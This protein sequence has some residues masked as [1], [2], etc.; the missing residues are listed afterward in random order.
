MQEMAILCRMAYRCMEIS[1]LLDTV[2]SILFSV[3]LVV[4]GMR[5][6]VGF[7]KKGKRSEE[8]KKR[9]RR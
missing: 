8:A 5:L 1:C 4:S 9:K 3:P 2:Y 6:E 7:S